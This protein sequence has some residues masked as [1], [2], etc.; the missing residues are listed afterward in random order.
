MRI[1]GIGTFG[2]LVAASALAGCVSGGGTGPVDTTPD[3]AKAAIS[4]AA[5]MPTLTGGKLTGC[6]LESAAG[7]SALPDDVAN[8]DTEATKAFATLMAQG[9][10]PLQ[11]Y[12]SRVRAYSYVPG[13]SAPAGE[14]P[15]V[16]YFDKRRDDLR[17]LVALTPN[18][19]PVI[20]EAA[21]RDAMLVA[22]AKMAGKSVM[23][24]K[25]EGVY[26]Q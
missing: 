24:V 12:A 4:D 6:L 2:I 7:R 10:Q 3:S 19:D 26:A 9:E 22:Y 21:V 23:K 11:Q 8:F 18:P 17:F 14:T 13:P 5:T 20:Q 16:C 15:L 1:S 25:A